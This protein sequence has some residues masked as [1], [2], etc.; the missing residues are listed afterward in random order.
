MLKS[1]LKVAFLI[2][3]ILSVTVIAGAAGVGIGL[4]GGLNISN[5]TGSDLLQGSNIASETKNSRLGIIIGAFV[6]F[7][8][9]DMLA[10]QPEFL[11][12]QKGGKYE[13]TLAQQAGS[14]FTS[15]IKLDYL[16]IPILLKASLLPNAAVIQPN[17]YFG[18][19]FAL[20]LKAETETVGADGQIFTDNNVPEG[21]NVKSNDYGLVFGGGL[22][23]NF[24]GPE[25]G[26]EA[27][28]TLGFT[29]WTTYQPVDMKN[30]T[31][32][33]LASIGFSP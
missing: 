29:D 12:T 2:T 13:G 32:S 21:D 31:F 3:T 27:R 9:S 1:I 23:F 10:I 24:S 15:E 5:L 22:D 17:L 28:Y 18:P 30:G 19:V 11:Y 25:I 4:K 33:I 7:N 16:E 20:K 14:A 8:I 26:I 6:A